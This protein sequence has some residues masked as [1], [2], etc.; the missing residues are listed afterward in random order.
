MTNS[1]KI[2]QPRALLALLGL[3]LAMSS[4]GCGWVFSG[5]CGK[6]D[7]TSCE[8]ICTSTG[9][10]QFC[11]SQTDL[12][13]TQACEDDCVKQFNTSTS[14]CNDASDHAVIPQSNP[15][16]CP[17]GETFAQFVF[18]ETCGDDPAIDEQTVAAGCNHDDALADAQAKFTDTDTTCSID[19]C[20]GD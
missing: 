19:D 9:A 20:T 10:A 16:V 5:G 6:N 1:I 14:F 12:A 7:K 11:G 8:C 17:A 18:C 3:V 2:E 4:A 13:G 15:P